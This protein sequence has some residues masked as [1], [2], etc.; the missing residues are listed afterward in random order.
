MQTSLEKLVNTAFSVC[1]SRIPCYIASQRSSI[2]FPHRGR[3]YLQPQFYGLYGLSCAFFRSH[4]FGMEAIISYFFAS[5]NNP[6]ATSFVTHYM[7]SFPH[8]TQSI[9]S[10]IRSLSENGQGKERIAERKTGKEGFKGRSKETR[11]TIMFKPTPSGSR[12]RGKAVADR[13]DTM[14]W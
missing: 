13:S 9:G 14:T 4:A 7:L 12:F 6:A 2:V 8:T 1:I 3:R 5:I 10:E 11:G